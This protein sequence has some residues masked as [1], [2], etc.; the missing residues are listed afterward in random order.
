MTWYRLTRASVIFDGL[1]PT[2]FE[3]QHEGWPAR[4]WERIEAPPPRPQKKIMD[5]VAV[6]REISGLPD[7]RLSRARELAAEALGWDIE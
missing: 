7:G 3:F 4:H 5:V 1:Q 2:G 6:L